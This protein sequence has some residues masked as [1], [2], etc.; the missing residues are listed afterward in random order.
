[1]EAKKISLIAG[2]Y[3]PV[4]VQEVVAKLIKHE[5]QFHRLQNFTSLIRFGAT[6]TRQ[7][8][9]FNISAAARRRLTGFWKWRKLKACTCILKL[10]YAYP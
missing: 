10:S 7:R 8:Q 5:L 4:Q 1:M 6:V 3:S 9:I 2:D